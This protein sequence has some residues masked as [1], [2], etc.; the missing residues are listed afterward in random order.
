MIGEQ[1]QWEGTATELLST[2][3]GYADDGKQRYSKAW[4]K[5]ANY[6]S[7]RLNMIAP[8]LRL[9]GIDISQPTIKRRKLWKFS[10]NTD[11]GV[12][13]PQFSKLSN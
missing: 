3:G 6:L 9:M 4:P 11:Q 1:E 7:Q 8:S 2:L 10:L 5:Q 13:E 12:D